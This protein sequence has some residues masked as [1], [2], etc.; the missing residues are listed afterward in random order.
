MRASPNAGSFA[1]EL[2]FKYVGG[3]P[4]VDLVNT[5]DW[6]EGAPGRD[7]LADYA[8]LTEW[9]EGAGVI[10]HGEGVRL[11]RKARTEPRAA[12][13][14]VREA[15]K[16]RSV[17]KR[18]FTGMTPGEREDTDAAEVFARFLR[19]ALRDIRLQGRAGGGRHEW[20]FP[21]ATS[22]LDG[23]LARVVW[24]AAQLLDSPDAESLGVCD[25][26]GCGWV[27]VD[28]SRNGLRRWCEMRTC[29]TEEKS[30]R[31]RR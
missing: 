31:R 24:A 7:R 8:R 10:S 15:R 30:R 29:G 4:S 26:P 1:P 25:G 14:A 20:V 5:I 6:P 19:R 21:R 27:F 23:F 2:P 3:D 9:A 12:E 22:A 11:R 17:L 16:L 13:A 18:M 28:R